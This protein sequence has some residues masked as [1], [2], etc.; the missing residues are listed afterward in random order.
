MR[1]PR[2]HRS[3][4]RS[5]LAVLVSD[6]PTPPARILVSVP[7]PEQLLAVLDLL[8]HELFENTRAVGERQQVGKPLVGQQRQRLAM[9]WSD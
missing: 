2:D 9:P 1:A 8:A 7:A 4:A 3:Q 6:H 5:A